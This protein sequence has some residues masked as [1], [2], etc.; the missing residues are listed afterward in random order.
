MIERVKL[1]F[2]ALPKIFWIYL[3]AL[4]V[5]EI[6]ALALRPDLPGLYTHILQYLALPIAALFLLFKPIRHNIRRWIYTLAGTAFVFLAL[7]YSLADYNGAGHAGLAQIVV[8]ACPVSFYWIVLFCRWNYRH[9]K[10]SDSRIALLLSSFAWGLY[11]FAYP[12]MPL[13]PAALLLLVPWFI[14]L[15]RYSRGQA[16][17]ATFWSGMLYNAINY[18][19]I[20]NV[21]HVE[22]APSGLILFGLF[23]LIAFFSAYNTLAGFI[24]TLARSATFKG[25]RILLP[26]YPLFYAGLE[27][28]RTKGD[29]AFPW[30]HLGYVFGNHLELLQMLPFIG[31]FG[32]TALV[33]GSNQA[34]AHAFCKFQ[35]IRKAVPVLAIPAAIFVLL[36]IQGCIVLSRPEAAPFNG[37]NSK[38]NPTIALVQPSI[39]QGA[40]WSKERFNGIVNKTLGMINDSVASKTDL[41]VLAETAIPDHIR[42]Q[43]R[44]IERLHRT[45]DH[46][47]ASILVGALDYKRNERGSIRKFD[48]YNASFLF[49]P[50]DDRFPQRYIKKHLVP[51]S[52]RIP[53][54]DLFPIL[55]YVDLGEGDFVTGKETPVYPPFNWTPY[56][57]YDA[58]FGDLVREAIREGSRMMV[59]ITNDGWFGRSTAPYQHLNLIRYRAIENGMPVARLANSG[60]SAYIDQYGH[61]DGNTEIFTD[62]VIQRKMPLKTRDT[63]YSHIGDA[64]ENALL[65][66]FAIYLLFA[67]ISLRQRH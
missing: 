45:A 64:V 63:L 34:V 7:D 1:K 27:M 8:T 55:N 42:R 66:F 32:Y 48:I 44:V 24:Y 58:I 11:A 36:L 5:V 10:S 60:I 12:P 50:Q 25:Y 4:L 65:V 43:P 67:L 56:I 19:W 33:I 59:N 51:F 41:I 31:I 28:T 40:K 3:A 39:Q 62:R 49:T 37:A 54:D 15:N 53:F 46:K 20:Y 9:I 26:L 47:N 6:I 13:G 30:S 18:Y 61:F 16:M 29:F 52:E 22:T 35:T 23:L 14:V 2:S 17:F 57:C 21:M 38:D